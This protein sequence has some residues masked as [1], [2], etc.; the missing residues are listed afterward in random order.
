M[1]V[2]ITVRGYYPAVK[3]GGPPVAIENIC[4]ATG[5]KVEYYIITTNHDKGETKVLDGI[6]SGWNVVGKANVIYLSPE[7]ETYEKFKEIIDEVKPDII[8]IQSLFDAKYT[9]NMLKLSK[10]TKIPLLLAVRG[11]L[12]SGVFTKKYK[13]LP[14][15][16]FLKF[17]G[18]LNNVHFHATYKE[19]EEGIKKVLCNKNQS[20]TLIQDLPVL[21]DFMPKNPNK[22]SGELKATFISR[23]VDNKNL[24]DVIKSLE[25]VKS[26]VE[27]DIYGFKQDPAYW[28]IC[29]NELKNLPDNITARYCGELLHEDV[30]R[31]L[32]NYDV[33]VFPTYSENYG[34]I[35]A[36][37]V[38]ASCPVIISDKTPW[39]NISETG[40]SYVVPLHNLE[41]LTT[42]IEE[43][44]LMNNG[45]Y[46]ELLLRLQKYVEMTLDVN[47]ISQRY[48]NMYKNA[49]EKN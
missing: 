40:A 10:K 27:F 14:Y 2:L 21:I 1:K 25:N 49:L 22:I 36:E 7:E 17:S 38:L 47:G 16:Y 11:E 23:I 28:E 42:A 29:E 8:Y 44:A 24:L 37:S 9:L 13:K 26:S 4:D 48:I 6:K 35:I 31:T 33:F 15:I 5:D 18:L 39:T 12:S 30:V 20:I 32:H 41:A 46:T 45:Q 19:E 43:M 34:Q 3:H